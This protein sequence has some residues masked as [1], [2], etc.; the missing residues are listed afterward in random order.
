MRQSVNKENKKVR[1]KEKG[2]RPSGDR[3]RRE[4]EGIE[5]EIGYVV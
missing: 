2:N 4:H 1:Q 5:I 3:G